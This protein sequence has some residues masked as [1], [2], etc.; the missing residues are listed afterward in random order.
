MPAGEV[1]LRCFCYIVCVQVMCAW[2]SW[3]MGEVRG[4]V[5]VQMSKSR[6]DSLRITDGNFTIA[7][8]FEVKQAQALA[9]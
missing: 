8:R 9:I 5:K 3:W 2:S 7:Q 6:C 1:G 4:C